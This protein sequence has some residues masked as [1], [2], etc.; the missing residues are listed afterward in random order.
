MAVTD[1][2]RAKALGLV[3]RS[4]T[5]EMWGSF[6]KPF[7]LDAWPRQLRYQSDASSREF[8]AIAEKAGDKYPEVVRLVLPYLRPAAHLDTFAYRTQKKDEGGEG[9]S[10]RFPAE[11][12]DLFDALVGDDSQTMPWNLGE[13]IETI[14]TAAPAL[15]QSN[16]WRRL[17]GLTQ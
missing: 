9:Y 7:I 10:E 3:A 4:M 17:K 2:D 14:A 12:L 1:E 6:I 11:T 5:D 15:R 13:I 8:A 16:K